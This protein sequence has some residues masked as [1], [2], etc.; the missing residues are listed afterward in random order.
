MP[1]AT[2]RNPETRPVEQPPTSP[3]RAH[4]YVTRHQTAETSVPA[5]HMA[6]A[7]T[8]TCWPSVSAVWARRAG[9]RLK[10]HVCTSGSA[11]L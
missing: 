8:N 11:A 9:A 1:H 3:L 2:M 10:N 5:V 4:Q 6:I 7:P